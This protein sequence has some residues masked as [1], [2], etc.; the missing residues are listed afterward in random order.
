MP[1]RLTRPIVGLIPTIPF[2]PDGHTIEP[3]VSVPMPTVARSAA[4]ADA[5]ARARAAGVAVEHVG[6]FVWP[7]TPLQPLDDGT[8]RKFAHSDRFALPMTIAPAARSRSTR[9]ASAGRA[10]RQRHEPPVVGMS[11]VFDVVLDDHR[12]AEQGPVVAVAPRAV[13]GPGLG[14]RVGRDG[15]DRVELRVELPDPVR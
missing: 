12:D 4:T 14:L 5:R 13:G 10:A 7:P 11:A 2:A 9:N 8:E 3:S 1:A 15:D 6:L